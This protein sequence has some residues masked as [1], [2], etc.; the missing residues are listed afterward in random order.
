MQVPPI[1][2]L[3]HEPVADGLRHPLVGDIVQQL[4]SLPPGDPR[5]GVA[6]DGL[7]GE[8]KI[9][10]FFQRTGQDAQLLLVVVHNHHLGRRLCRSRSNQTA[11]SILLL[12]AHRQSTARPIVCSAPYDPAEENKQSKDHRITFGGWDE[13]RQGAL[14][15]MYMLLRTLLYMIRCC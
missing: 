6:S 13:G 8:N 3:H 5:L 10:S 4:T 15:Q 2:P 11:R 14:G 7:A 9:R 1:D 12:D